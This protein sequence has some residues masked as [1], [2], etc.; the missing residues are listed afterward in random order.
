MS[1][2]FGRGE[3]ASACKVCACARSRAP[4]GMVFKGK[5]RLR[6]SNCSWRS[7]VSIRPRCDSASGAV[8]PGGLAGICQGTRNKTLA[9]IFKNNS[10][11]RTG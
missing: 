1:G 8:A 4:E 7:R 2:P 11:V 3:L 10:T 9:L 5:A 6:Y